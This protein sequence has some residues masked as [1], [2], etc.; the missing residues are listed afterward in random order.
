MIIY[1]TSLIGARDANEDCHTIIV[2]EDGKDKK[3]EDINMFGVYDGHG[4]PEISKFLEKELSKYFI[5]KKNKLLMPLSKKYILK[6]YQHLS[7]KLEKELGKKAHDAG[8]TCL[9]VLQYKIKEI[10]YI[11]VINLGDSRAVLCRNNFAI[12]L[13][14]DH[15]P[16]WPE[17]RKRIESIIKK[18]GSSDKIVKDGDD[19]R[20][21]NLSVSRAFGDFDTK[22]YITYEPD[23]FKYRLIKEQDLFMILA[24]D[25]LWDVL[26]SQDVI[27]FILEHLN[28][29][30]H[31]DTTMERTVSI[32]MSAT[33]I[34]SK[35][36][37]S[38]Q[39]SV[40]SDISTIG[41]KINIAEKLGEYAIKKGSGDNITI[42]IVIL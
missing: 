22:T 35:R 11:Q 36:N 37:S 30:I 1:E 18:T 16:N 2:N 13:T 40:I 15:K 19:W 28:V 42:I 27:N 5:L 8:S 24:C 4:G 21:K 32:K 9:V 33:S 31:G 12:P 41:E 6:I 23:I 39:T 29:D 10:E 25:G 7:A 20:I 14:K 34:S 26:S 17:E 3:Y 38:S